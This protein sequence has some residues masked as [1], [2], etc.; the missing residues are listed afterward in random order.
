ML[1][2]GG[3]APRPHRVEDG[4]DLLPGV[5]IAPN[6]PREERIERLERGKV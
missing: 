4:G 5:L 6:R 3:I 2:D 1:P